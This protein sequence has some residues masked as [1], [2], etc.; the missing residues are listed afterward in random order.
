[1]G[2]E[3]TA[4]DFH[5]LAPTFRVGSVS[6]TLYPRHL[7][8]HFLFYAFLARNNRYTVLIMFVIIHICSW[9]Q[10]H[11]DSKIECL[12]W[13]RFGNFAQFIFPI[14][15]IFYRISTTHLGDFELYSKKHFDTSLQFY[16]HD[17]QL[18]FHILWNILPNHFRKLSHV[19]FPN[20]LR[21]ITFF[22]YG[23]LFS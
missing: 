16:F 21:L 7:F 22:S 19:N 5:E 4:R 11:Y 3:P 13:D 12:C 17:I 2:S 8:L 15:D 9:S 20:P 18:T 23:Q 1:M 10:I 6:T 14:K